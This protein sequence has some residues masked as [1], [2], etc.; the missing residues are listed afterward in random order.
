MGAIVVDLYPMRYVGT[1]FGL[2]AAGSALGGFAST[3]LVGKLASTGSYSTVFLLM[4]MLHPLAWVIAWGSV[5]GK[6]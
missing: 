4:G 1:V 3:Q 2:I 6:R 5:R